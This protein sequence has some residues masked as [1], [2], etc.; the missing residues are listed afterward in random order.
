TGYSHVIYNLFTAIG[1][2]ILI[3]PFTFVWES[4]EPGGLQ[5]NGE[6]ALV[7]FHTLFNTVGVIAILPLTSRFEGLMVQLVPDKGPGY[8][9]G[10]ETGLLEQPAL[11]ISAVQNS[12][13]NESLALLYHLNALLGAFSEEKRA[14]LQDLQA[15]LDETYAYIDRI[16]LKSGIDADWERLI[17]L[18][19]TL[20]HLQ[21]LHERCEEEED[22]AIT[23]RE[24]PE[25]I[26]QRDLLIDCVNTILAAIDVANWS[27]AVKVSGKV[28]GE[29]H[30]NVK[31]YRLKIMEKIASGEM[32]IAEGTDCLEAIRWLRR[33]SKH[34]ARIMQ[35]YTDSLVASGK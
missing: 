28:S 23:A 20:D 13:K 5:T 6:I 17:A 26:E 4:L 1:A 15:A 7:A 24:T 12:V 19:H 31:P 34:I 14:D 2:L 18:I 9:R 29:I 8:T 22:R 3:T 30:D 27:D 10:L 16:N 32:S 21:R 33:V 11:A 25:L 35:H